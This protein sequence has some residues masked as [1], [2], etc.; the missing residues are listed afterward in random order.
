MKTSR[1]SEIAPLLPEKPKM[2]LAP[3]YARPLHIL[4]Q[5]RGE[6][7]LRPMLGR[8]ALL[9][10][11]LLVLLVVTVRQ[12]MP[13]EPL[14][15]PGVA[16]VFQSG[17]KTGPAVPNPTP[18]QELPRSQATPTPMPKELPPTPSPPEAAAPS[19]P[20]TERA[21]PPA[22]AQVAPSTS[23]EQA[24]SPA[25]APRVE[26]Q[27]PPT[28]QEP[29]R[30]SSAEAATQPS[31]A[32]A[33]ATPSTSA[34]R[35]P[36]P[37]VLATPAPEVTAVR[38]PAPAVQKQM[39]KSLEPQRQTEPARLA[40]PAPEVVSP[41]KPAPEK[42]QKS[43]MAA[44]RPMVHPFTRPRPPL[45]FP[46]PMKFSFGPTFN[47]TSTAMLEGPHRKGAMVLT[48]RADFATAQDLG[49]DWRN[50]FAAWL[51]AHKYYPPD[52]AMRGEQGLSTVRVV[53]NADGTIVS[54]ALRQSSGY[55]TLDD[56]TVGLFHDARL[57]P[58]PFGSPDPTITFDLTIHYIL[59]R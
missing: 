14:P 7:G 41:S 28:T 49:A 39:A 23:T 21:V 11:I 26:A 36:A 31:K 6:G 53:M 12:Q 27:P 5:R 43:E 58:L 9:H 19:A 29:P 50:L 52:A 8:S 34:A 1:G 24:A 32:L 20:P 44:A 30:P 57:P 13:S 42:A 56:A 10:L 51:E 3:V 59:L 37:P 25:P 15:P 48:P 40:S 2:R 4:S 38:P 47:G 17:S 55:R 45:K 22:P 54:V 18:F 33:P 46:A 16:V 35:N